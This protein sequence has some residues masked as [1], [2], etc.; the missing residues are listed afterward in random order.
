ML[1]FIKLAMHYADATNPQTEAK[2]YCK[3]GLFINKDEL[4]VAFSHIYV[5]GPV[6]S[7][8]SVQVS[9]FVLVFLCCS[10]LCYWF[11]LFDCFPTTSWCI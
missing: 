1:Q 11:H 9:V 4:S 3:T 5:S 7:F 6:R 8:C 10:D 2:A